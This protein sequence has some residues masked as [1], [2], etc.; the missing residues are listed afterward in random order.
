MKK[1]VLLVLGLVSVAAFAQTNVRVRG[2]ITALNGDV[3][4]V[5]SRE[6]KEVKVQLAPDAQV[7]VAKATTL[8]MKSFVLSY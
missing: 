7:A 3:L 5:K 2:T 8:T 1:L 6:G 4:T